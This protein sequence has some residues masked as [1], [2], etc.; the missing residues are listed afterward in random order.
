MQI[1]RMIVVDCVL[2]QQLPIAVIDVIVGSYGGHVLAKIQRDILKVGKRVSDIAIKR[3]GV[4]VQAGKHQT[5][6]LPHARDLNKAQ[7]RHI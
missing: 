7:A 5:K 3:L 4:G 1:L 6:D 2:H